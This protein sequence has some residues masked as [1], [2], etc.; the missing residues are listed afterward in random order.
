[1]DG[2]TDGQMNRIDG[3]MDRIDGKADRQMDMQHVKRGT[4]L[5]QVKQSLLILSDQCLWFLCFMFVFLHQS[6]SGIMKIFSS[7]VF[8]ILHLLLLALARWETGP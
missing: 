3:W 4:Q 1:M 7:S 2:W 5:N 8:V 6:R